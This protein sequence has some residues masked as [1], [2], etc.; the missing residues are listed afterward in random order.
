MLG[1]IC[2]EPLNMLDA[3]GP[4]LDYQGN[5]HGLSLTA[6]ELLLIQHILDMI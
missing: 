4:S 1:M 2:D 3:Y 5:P 6:L